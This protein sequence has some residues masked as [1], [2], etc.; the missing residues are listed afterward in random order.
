VASDDIKSLATVESLFRDAPRMRIQDE[1]EK[2]AS[3]KGLIDPIS[4]I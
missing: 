3:Y 4:A 1:L 2:R